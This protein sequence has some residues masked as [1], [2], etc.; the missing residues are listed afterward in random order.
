[1]SDLR[2]A[3]RSLFKNRGFAAFAIVT[4]GVGVGATT[5][6]FSV[7]DGVL[8]KPLP[9]VEPSRL[10]VVW[11]ENPRQSI[12]RDV[13][14]YPNFEQWRAQNRVFDPLVAF[15]DTAFNLTGRGEPEEVD[16]IVA[17]SGFFRLLGVQ[18]VEG[19][20]FTEPDHHGA[21]EVAVISYGLWQRRFGGRA[22]VVGQPATL[23]GRT[24]TIVGVLPARFSFMYPADVIVP[25]VPVGRF[26]SLMGQRGALWLN[27]VGRLKPGIAVA[28]AQGE[29]RGIARR[30]EEQYPRANEG[31][32]IAIEP[33]QDVLVTDVRR[34]LLILLGAVGLLL[35]IAC[36]NVANLLLVR[37]TGRRREIA[38]RLALGASRSRVARHLVVEHFTVF[39]LGGVAGA[40]LAFWGVDLLVRLAPPDLPRLA[41]VALDLRAL[42]FALAALLATGVIFGVAPALHASNAQP[43]E[44]LNEQGRAPMQGAG[45]RRLRSVI[46]AGELAVALMLLTGAS[47]MIRSVLRLQA[48]EPGFQPRGLLTLQLSVPR[49]KYTEPERVVGF[50]GELLDRVRALPDVRS[51]AAA[52]TLLLSQLPSSASVNIEGRLATSAADRIPVAM[53]AI[54]PGFFRTMGIPIR[55]GRDVNDADHQGGPQV[56]VINE[57]MARQFWPGQDPLGRR[58]TFD[59]LDARNVSWYSVVG[60]AGDVRRSGL[61]LEPRPEVYFPH[62]QS[63]STRMTLVVRTGGDPVLVAGPVRQALWSLDPDQPITNVRTGEQLVAEELHA[64][65][66]TMTL[67]AIFA[68]AALFLAA[69]GIYG[70]VAYAVLER[71]HEI[72]VRIALGARMSN[73]L[74]LVMG[75]GLQ[76]AAVGLALGLA[77][78]V[79][80][81]RA[82]TGLL[83][84]I[85]PNDATTLAGVAIVVL[86]IS[87]AATYIPA[88]RA[89]RVDPITALRAE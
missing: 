54:T 80:G 31:M 79:W 2:H 50:Y 86:L 88:R 56:A 81:A 68:G 41:D 66:F 21:G 85:A 76:V 42:G 16:A 78:S 52:S 11:V 48:V 46:V 29:M 71:T 49:A 8:L 82:L 70:V 62:R 14:S 47:L 28:A 26:Q 39:A 77:G 23:S 24:H 10:M 83:Y 35:A 12:A 61:T 17:T 67:L 60:V 58:F 25:L 19:R 73:V 5:A 75:Q 27:V 69:L 4:L 9:F 64:H 74:A 43:A 51:A 22:E 84:G 33:L 45:S 57:A 38:I 20:F 59:A 87:A 55:R 30:L 40:V 18:P 15:A 1:M 32:S 34:P 53:D 3:I 36:A 37:G 89:L 7:V 63:P 6:I 13:T 72:G 44:A 65:R